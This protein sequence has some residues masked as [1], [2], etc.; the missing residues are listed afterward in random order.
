MDRR[1]VVAQ[2]PDGSRFD[3]GR[4]SPSQLE[5][6]CQGPLQSGIAVF[7]RGRLLNLHGA[8]DLVHVEAVDESLLRQRVE[9]IVDAIRSGAF[10][11]NSPW[12]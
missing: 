6:V 2:A 11:W 9:S 10:K 4:A 1:W 5:R 3:V 7:R 12:Q 8:I